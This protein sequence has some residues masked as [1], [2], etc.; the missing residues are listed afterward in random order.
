VNQI[1]AR[2]GI[3]PLAAVTRDNIRHERRVEL[4]FE[5]HRY[6][7]ERRWRTA[8]TDLSKPLSGI[9]YI[10]DVS[11]GKYQLQVINNVD[12]ASNVP[13]FRPE[14]YYFPITIARTSNNPKLVENPGYH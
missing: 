14:N 3:A 7:D 8:V 2:A 9:R 4:A 12:G 5:G 1:R 6:W 11:T 13:Q 10:L